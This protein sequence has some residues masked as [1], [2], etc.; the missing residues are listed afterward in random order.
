MK[1]SRHLTAIGALALGVTACS[2]DPATGTRVPRS[3]E[4][5][6]SIAVSS[7]SADVGAKVAVAVDIDPTATP[8]G[9]L[10]G[11]LTYD[12]ARFA[13]CRPVTHRRCGQRRQRKGRRQGQDQF[14]Q[15]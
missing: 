9:G 13:V 4:V 12:A 7:G 1:F 5:P 3:T 10:Q 2:D 14:R 11:T 6:L 8:T 15:L